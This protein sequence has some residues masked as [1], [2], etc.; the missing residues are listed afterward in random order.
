MTW[1]LD[2]FSP[3]NTL[4]IIHPPHLFPV[5]SDDLPSALHVTTCIDFGWSAGFH[6]DRVHSTFYLAA[7]PPSALHTLQLYRVLVFSSAWVVFIWFSVFCSFLST[8]FLRFSSLSSLSTFW[9][10][11]VLRA[12]HCICV[13]GVHRFFETWNSLNHFTLSIWH[14]GS[15]WWL[16][17]NLYCPYNGRIGVIMSWAG[18]VLNTFE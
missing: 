1:P 2:A 5:I 15:H 14:S 3:V 6:A 4:H 12:P 18:S 8:S 9:H 17:C 16:K 10:G 7:I 13:D 11:W